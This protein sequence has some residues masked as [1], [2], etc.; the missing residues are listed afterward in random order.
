MVKNLSLALLA[1]TMI[2]FGGCDQGDGKNSSSSGVFLAPVPLAVNEDGV[3]PVT[4]EKRVE[5]EFTRDNVVRTI[6]PAL[7][8][9]NPDASPRTT[10][11]GQISETEYVFFEEE[12]STIL[13]ADLSQ[14]MPLNPAD[15]SSSISRQELAQIFGRATASFSRQTFLTIFDDVIFGYEPLVRSLFIIQKDGPDADQKM[16]LT[17]L[18]DATRIS[19]QIRLQTFNFNRAHKINE[20]INNAAERVVEI[21]LISAVPE[22]DV[23][24]LVVRQ[25]KI[26][27]D[28]T[29]N[30]RVFDDNGLPWPDV[31]AIPPFESVFGFL[32]IDQI[33]VVAD[34]LFVDITQFKPQNL[35]G[36]QAFLMFEDATSNFLLVNVVRDNQ[37][38][39]IGNVVD[40]FSQQGE[41]QFTIRQ[42]TQGDGNAL[43]LLMRSS[44]HLPNTTRILAF[45]ENTN[46]MLELDYGKP[47]G[48][49][50]VTLYANANDLLQRR[51]HQVTDDDIEFGLNE[52][53]LSFAEGTL[54][55]DNILLFDRGNDQLISLNL[56]T[57][58]YVV[59]LKQSDLATATG[60]TGIS[61]LTY[62]RPVTDSEAIALDSDGNAM[63]RI[64][65]DYAVFPVFVSNT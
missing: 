47:Q 57:Q 17:I 23:Q 7:I 63:V 25:D 39:V 10:L 27:G 59:I 26:T 51:D 49:R 43:D 2:L 48:T 11:M 14:D 54:G 33:R 56:T 21:L 46:N 4:G 64:R 30:F 44:I 62:I 5:A 42:G 15:P 19:Q 60:L 37:G 35:P 22:Q 41:V 40:L 65:M 8:G 32:R 34:S 45:E 6:N 50:R 18:M 38:R 1:A 52:P 55:E 13:K 3:N 61:D 9:G 12:S 53:E 36:R 24:M 31:N 58:L 29:A 16:D 20:V 28:I